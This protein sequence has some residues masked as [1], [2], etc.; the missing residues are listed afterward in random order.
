[1]TVRGIN[2][3]PHPCTRYTIGRHKWFG[4]GCLFAVDPHECDKHD[5]L[6]VGL[7]HIGGGIWRRAYVGYVDTHEHGARFFSARDHTFAVHKGLTLRRD[8][9]LNSLPCPNF[10]LRERARA[11]LRETLTGYDEEQIVACLRRHLQRE[12]A[13]LSAS[14]LALPERRPS[15]PTELVVAGIADRA[16]RLTRS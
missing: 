1:M 6:L 2:P 10:S 7:D 5:D 15:D 13:V 9:F 3:A 12:A 4:D 16:G 11:E 14:A 8:S